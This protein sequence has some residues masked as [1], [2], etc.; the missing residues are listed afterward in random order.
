MG[1]VERIFLLSFFQRGRINPE[2]LAAIITQVLHTSVAQSPAKDP[3][4]KVRCAPFT[5][6]LERLSA[7]EHEKGLV[8]GLDLYRPC[9]NHPWGPTTA[10]VTAA[11]HKQ[12]RSSL[13][14][15]LGK[16]QRSM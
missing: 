14:H 16:N 7:L 9:V 15:G 1:A 11:Q 8:F 10:F 12:T 5:S 3:N 13:S 2:L 6:R 4:A